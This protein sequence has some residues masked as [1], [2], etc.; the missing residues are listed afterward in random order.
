M[1]QRAELLIFRVEINHHYISNLR[2][3]DLGLVKD[4]GLW[5]YNIERFHPFL[6]SK[7]TK[8]FDDLQTHVNTSNLPKL[9]FISAVLYARPEEAIV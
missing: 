2:K 6:K 7:R 8:Y 4:V 1:E 5:Q 9:W 3:V